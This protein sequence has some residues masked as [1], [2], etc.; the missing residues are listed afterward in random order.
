[1]AHPS[2]TRLPEKMSTDR[3]RLDALFADTVVGH[4]AFV[5]GAGRPAVVPT[6]VVLDGDRLLLHG[7]TG[8]HWMR[9]VVGRPVAVSVTAIDGVVVART[10][11]ESS[12]AYRSAVLTG[13]CQVVGP[14]AQE[15]A[16]ARVT[17]RIVPG[18][19]AEVR[20]STRRELAATLVLEMAI[21][22]WSLRIS[23]GPPTDEPDD[24]A[25]PAWAG[26]L[27]VERTYA[28]PAA[29]PDL[30]DGIAVPASVSALLGDRPRL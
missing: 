13:T 18:R 8:S 28:P 24:V 10:A 26:T 14:D 12:L 11:F 4:V 5:D 30:R 17:E 3:S 19:V 22:D 29:A 1:M 6:A 15:A 27:T 23:T 25:G 21:E 20:G 7:S 9:H 2:S 16:L